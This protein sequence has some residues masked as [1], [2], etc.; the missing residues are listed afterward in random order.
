MSHD[1]RSRLAGQVSSVEGHTDA[2]LSEGVGEGPRVVTEIEVPLT[3]V[4][5]LLLGLLFALGVEHRRA[6]DQLG[7]RRRHSQVKQPV[8]RMV[9]DD[10]PTG[11]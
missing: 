1:L 7:L 4:L 11:D 2:S 9:A 3:Q 8:A 5:D 6:V 10:S